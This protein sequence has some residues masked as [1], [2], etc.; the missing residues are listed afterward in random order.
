MLA[1][2]TK[3]KFLSGLENWKVPALLTSCVDI[4]AT[5]RRAWEQSSPTLLGR[6]LCEAWWE[7]ASGWGPCPGGSKPGGLQMNDRLVCVGIVLWAKHGVIET[8]VGYSLYYLYWAGLFPGHVILHGMCPTGYRRRLPLRHSGWG[9]MDTHPG[10][11][12]VQVTGASL[13]PW[14]S[15]TGGQDCDLD[16]WSP[17]YSWALGVKS[18]LSSHLGPS[19]RSWGALFPLPSEFS[20]LKNIL[21]RE[22]LGTSEV[23]G[24]MA[25]WLPRRPSATVGVNTGVE[26]GKVEG[27]KVWRKTV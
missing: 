24:V 15:K 20:C 7:R 13:V 1:G 23:C 17:V 8:W 21:I 9:A 5:H 26:G 22:I 12:D 3:Q 4:Q 19:L 10:G 11:G 18:L 6:T 14:P 25:S 27:E 2:A 16:I